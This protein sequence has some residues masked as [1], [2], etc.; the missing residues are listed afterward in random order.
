MEA[1]YSAEANAQVTKSAVADGNLTVAQSSASVANNFT[2]TPS[3]IAASASLAY[4]DTSGNTYVSVYN[5]SS[6][7]TLDADTQGAKVIAYELKAIISYSGD[8]NTQAS[9]Q[10][11]WQDTVAQVKLKLTCTAVDD[12]T[13][14]HAPLHGRADTDDVRFTTG[15]S[16]YSSEGA[17]LVTKPASAFTF[18]AVSGTESPYSSVTAEVTVGTVY[19]AL[20][21]NNDLVVDA[22][23]MPVYT[24]TVDAVETE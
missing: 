7:D 14:G 23:H 17:N 22:S 20:S 8:L 19:V 9:I 10:A 1:W 6:Y 11:L 13:T 3:A 2:V 18:G 16:D 24:L 21:G 12:T 4:T 15:S 5:G